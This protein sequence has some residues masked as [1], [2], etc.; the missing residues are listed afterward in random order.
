MLFIQ[1][2]HEGMKIAGI[3]LCKSK[4]AA[5]TRNGKSYENVMLMD[6]TGTIDAKIW[7]PD[8]AA[9]DDF[10]ALDYVDI[11]G[12]VTKYNGNLQ[13]SLKRVR[14]AQEGEYEPK[15]YL[16]VSDKNPEEMFR[17]LMTYLDKV[18]N[19]FLHR[20]LEIFF[21]ED[22]ELAS[23]FRTASAARTIHHSFVGGLLQ[24]TL[25]V[26]NMC[27]FFTRY[28]PVLNRDL[29][30]TAAMLHDIGKVKEISPFPECD[31]TD[32]GQLLGHIMIGAEMIHDA[33][34]KIE[35]FPARLESDLKHCI[36]AHHGEYEYG[37]P[38]KP[39]L[40]EALALNLADNADA[41]LESMTELMRA[42]VQKGPNEWFG[43]NRIFDSNI[44]KTGD[45]NAL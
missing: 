23:R 11:I 45:I 1:E 25:Y 41:K 36:L 26:T 28:Y 24:H 2:M 22:E 34:G 6:R 37:S 17:A 31:Y 43:F 15:D 3:Y 20:L 14:K 7:E 32:D 39:A 40:A 16:P 4:N 8:S 5:V 35:G 21:R 38:K 18:E 19:P 10:D 12:D 30:L 33:A 29:L 13:L 9:I 42:N 44:R 27:Y